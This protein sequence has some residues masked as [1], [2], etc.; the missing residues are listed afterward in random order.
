MRMGVTNNMPSIV[1]SVS[2]Q[3]LHVSNSPTKYGIMFITGGQKHS[4]WLFST[5]FLPPMITLSKFFHTV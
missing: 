5:T 3:Y 4:S 2:S 1:S